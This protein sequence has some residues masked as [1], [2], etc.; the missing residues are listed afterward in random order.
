M[1]SSRRRKPL[2][3]NGRTLEEVVDLYLRELDN[4][5]PDFSMRQIYRQWMREFVPEYTAQK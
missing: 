1:L 5:A 3:I 4:P 2:V